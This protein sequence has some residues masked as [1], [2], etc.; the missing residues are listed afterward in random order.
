MIHF[1]R[2]ALAVLSIVVLLLTPHGQAWGQL[3]PVGDWDF[4]LSG[5]ERGV[6]QVSLRPDGS[7]TGLAVFTFFSRTNG[8]IPGGGVSL[9][10]LFGAA[11]LQ[12]GWSFRSGSTRQI[13]G[14]I[15]FLSMEVGTTTDTT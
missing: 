1:S 10:N 11:D 12:G 7:L 15:N 14:Y 6:A 2:R 5:R 13:L 4:V 3:T 9:T 8:S